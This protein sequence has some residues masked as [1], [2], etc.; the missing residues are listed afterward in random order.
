MSTKKPRITITLEPTTYETLSRLS[1]AGGESMSEIVTGFLAVCVPSMERMVLVMERAKTAPEEAKAGLKA[2]ID[3]VERAVLPGM[4]KDLEQGDLFLRDVV[5][6]AISASAESGGAQ[7]ARALR[8]GSSTPVLV[9]R[10]SGR[11]EASPRVPAKGGKR[12]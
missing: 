2:A 1:V 10:G 7:R 6:A 11:A 12:G 4:V 8:S 5:E 9:T 3:K